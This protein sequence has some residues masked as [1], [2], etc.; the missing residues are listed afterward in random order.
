MRE[1]VE[2]YCVEQHSTSWLHGFYA[3]RPFA[4]LLRWFEIGDAFPFLQINCPGSLE[5]YERKKKHFLLSQ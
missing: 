4:A 5:I 1:M 3:G 2:E